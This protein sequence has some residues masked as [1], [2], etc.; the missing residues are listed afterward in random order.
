METNLKD[1]RQSFIGKEQVEEYETRYTNLS[2]SS[3]LWKIEKNILD[4]EVY[5][6]ENVKEKK[7][8][9]FACGTGR[10]ISHMEDFFGESVGIDISS[11]MLK[12]AE[13]SSKH[14]K[15]ICKDITSDQDVIEGS[16][17]F[18]TAFRFFLHSDPK[19]QENVIRNLKKRLK[20]KDSVLVVNNHGNRY[21]FLFPFY[22][23]DKIRSV[24]GLERLNKGNCLVTSDLVA[25]LEANGLSVVRRY[26]FG[27]SPGF[28]VKL[29][30]LNILY[31]MEEKGKE[32]ALFSRFGIDQMLVCKI[33]K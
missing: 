13:R 4:Q 16:Y 8:L 3:F 21:S 14:S 1:Y 12:A 33:K 10:I 30:P 18:I 26:G 25:L 9:D 23:I 6:L 11:E 29:L 7:Y 15:L 19:L 32:S 31:F 17:D 27:F 24:L 2:L 28:L 5:N 22:I 20:N